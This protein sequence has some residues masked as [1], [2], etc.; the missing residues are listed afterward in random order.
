MKVGLIS[1]HSFV[2]PGGVK[3]HILGLSNAFDKMGIENKIIVPRRKFL[4][5]MIKK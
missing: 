2:N 4:K 3:S 5:I 1:S